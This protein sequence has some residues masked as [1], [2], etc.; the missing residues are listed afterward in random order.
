MRILMIFLDGVGLGSDD[1]T[2]NPFAAAHTPTLWALAGGRKWLWDT[3]R[4]DSER[5]L[6]IPTDPRLGVAGRPQSASSQAAILTGRNVPALIGEHYGPKPNAAIR[7]IL[8][9]PDNLFKQVRARGLSAALLDAYP[10][11]FFAG[12][13]R[14]KT[15]RSSI[16]QAAF[17]AD[18]P[19]RGEDY[20]RRGEALSVDWTGEGWRSMLGYSDTPVYSRPEAGALLGSLAS[21]YHFSFFSH[22]ITDEI[23]HRGPLARGI[24]ILELFDQVLAGLLANWDDQAGLIVITSDH[25][26]LE[27]V[28]I[29]QHTENNVPTVII[30]AARK[31]FGENLQALT[32]LTPAVMSVLT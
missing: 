11:Q 18:V 19:I 1:P 5:A 16:Q 28:S 27:D 4:I 22:W 3:P 23:G 9:Q 31:A 8:A 7:A 10:P 15:L 14:G 6:F 20:L 21:Q 26:N 24:A 13:D 17:E 25:G 32:D 30:G 2:I 12:I 29:R